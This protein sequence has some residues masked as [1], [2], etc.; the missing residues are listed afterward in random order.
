M[1]DLLDLATS[2]EA[3]RAGFQRAASNRAGPGP[4]GVSLLDFSRDLDAHLVALSMDLRSGAY[5]PMP[6][7]RILLER[8]DGRSRKVVLPCVRDRIVHHAL[9]TVLAKH[10]DEELRPS[11]YAYRKGRSGRMAI[12]AL[13]QQLRSGKDW[14]FR[15]DVEDFFDHID[16]TLVCNAIGLATGEVALVSLIET[17]LKAGQFLGGVIFDDTAGT[18]QGSALS[19]FLANLVMVPFDSAIEAMGLTMIRYGDDLCVPLASYHEAAQAEGRV[20]LELERLGLRLSEQKVIIARVREG[21]EFLG[22][23]FNEDGRRPGE[24]AVQKMLGKLDAL[25]DSGRPD[26]AEDVDHLLQGWI[27]YYGPLTHLPLP[28]AILPRA[29]QIEAAWAERRQLQQVQGE[30]GEPEVDASAWRDEEAER[31]ARQGNFEQAASVARRRLPLLPVAPRDPA[32][33]PAPDA[34]T[35]VNGVDDSPDAAPQRTPASVIA[36]FGGC[37]RAQELYAGCTVL[38]AL[39]DR[40]TSGQGLLASERFLVADILGR[41]GDEA[42]RACDSVFRHLADHKPGMARRF[43]SKLFPMPTS[44]ARIRQRMPELTAE[45]GCDCRFRLQAGAYPTPV[46]HVLG[47]AE[48]PGLE[49]RVQKATLKRTAAKAVLDAMNAGRKDM[50]DKAAALCTRLADARRQ[51]R[52]LSQQMAE[53]E[54]QLASLIDEAGEGALET[55]AGT[56]RK[57][58]DESGRSRFIL[59][60]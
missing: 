19:P 35:K 6:G 29:E 44:C 49:G 24:R 22:F 31:L 17:L 11:A 41:I 5:Q 18:P 27:A 2:V 36:V 3:L 33:P 60:V 40:A 53:M 47:A 23:H 45:V 57:L 50:G 37:G 13:D 15:G 7:Q 46:L 26:I 14:I 9:A 38:R 1:A 20:R 56:L 28:D 16:H 32:P 34:A 4:D 58:V 39:V 8:P 43:L 30:Q 42:E 21:F 55:P 54:D 10:L 51:V 52:L 12:E 25:L 59:E 48:I